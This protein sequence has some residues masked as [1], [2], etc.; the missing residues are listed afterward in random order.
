MPTTARFLSVLP[1]ILG[2]GLTSPAPAE[3]DESFQLTATAKDLSN[4]FP[5]YLAN[6]Y[7]STL[8]TPRGTQGTPTYLVAFMDYSTD[9]MSRPAA[10]PGWTEIDYSTGPSPTGQAWLNR[11]SFDNWRFRDYHQTLNL[12]EATLTTNYTY[13]DQDRNTA[14]A[15]TTFVDQANPHLAVSQ[16]AI[17][18]EFD[19]VVQLS[20]AM[21]LWA[22]YQP[23]LALGKLTGDEMEEQLLA[24]GQNTDA[25]PP[26]TP[27]RAAL[28]YRGDTHVT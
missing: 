14:V 26:A 6:G 20:F 12:R 17:T 1:V 13:V 9:D 7:V 28:W 27:N 11:G 23:R 15:V 5:A 22:P 10:V 18:P 8:S 21:N 2:L 24:Q 4:Y 3:I 25:V 16:I 19:G